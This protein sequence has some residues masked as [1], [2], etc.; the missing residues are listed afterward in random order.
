MGNNSSSTNTTKQL[1]PSQLYVS[2]TSTHPKP[3]HLRGL[4]QR[5]RTSPTPHG[6]TNTGTGAAGLQGFMKGSSPFA[7]TGK[8]NGGSK[9]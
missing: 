7:G 1:T 3:P 6:G 8:R 9:L 5:L 2:H 4:D